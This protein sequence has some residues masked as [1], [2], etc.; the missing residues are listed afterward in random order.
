MGA[1]GRGKEEISPGVGGSHPSCQ[2]PQW[3][4]SQRTSNLWHDEFKSKSGTPT[5]DPC[6][7]EMSPQNHWVWEPMRLHPGKVWNCKEW[8]TH[9]YQAWAQTCCCCCWITESCPTLCDPMGW[10]TPGA[11]TCLVQKPGQGHQAEKHKDIS[12][13]NPLTN[14]EAFDGEAGTRWE[15]LRELRYCWK[16][17]LQPQVPC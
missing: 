5:L 9:S 10:S 12:E 15:L 17:V 13:G 1:G 2:D 3:E 8:S 7:G 6:R 11:Q 14:F 16:P 4:G